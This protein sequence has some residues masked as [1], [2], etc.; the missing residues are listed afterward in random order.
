MLNRT[1]GH[2]ISQMILEK[3]ATSGKLGGLVG[4][5][6][7]VEAWN[8]RREGPLISNNEAAVSRPGWQKGA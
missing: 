4:N 1:G 7:S 6:F 3:L 8:H 5:P 2:K